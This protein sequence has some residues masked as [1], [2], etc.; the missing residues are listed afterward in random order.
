[1][2]PADGWK[3]I[4]IPPVH[5]N[6]RLT[7]RQGQVHRTTT[8]MWLSQRRHRWPVMLFVPR[9]DAG[10]AKRSRMAMLGSSVTAVGRIPRTSAGDNDIRVPRPAHV[11]VWL[12]RV[13]KG[14]SVNW[15]PAH[16]SA[17]D[18]RML[19]RETRIYRL[20]AGNQT[21]PCRK[22]ETFMILRVLFCGLSCVKECGNDL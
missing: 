7:E 15:R 18:V 17:H 2:D 3:I 13:G 10:R 22:D 14:W 8:T 21:F 12:G 6:G 4:S 9:A 1:M 16:R 20:R 11:K 5:A 19:L